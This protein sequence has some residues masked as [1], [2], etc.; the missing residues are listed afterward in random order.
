M[1]SHVI[2]ANPTS[3]TA[4]R[5]GRF[6]FWIAVSMSVLTA[7]TLA[8]AATTLPRSGP[9]CQSGCVAYPY[10]DIAAFFPRDYVWMWL[11]LLMAP[12]FVVLM[13][14][15][16]HYAALEQKLL[17]LIGLI[18]ASMAAVVIA[19]VYFV[20]LTVIQPSL[21]N[22]ETAGIALLTQYNPHGIFIALE[23]LGYLLMS[24][25]F[26]FAGAV[27]SAPGRLERTLRWIFMAGFG[28]SVGGLIVL[29]LIYGNHLEYRFEVLVIM[30]V[31]LVLIVT[32]ALLSVLFRRT[33][34]NRA[35]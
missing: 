8:V 34:H 2:A 35:A 18:F 17:S 10:T 27:F 20:Q 21:L 7:V 1:T 6:S 19:I 3:S 31:W 12:L 29:S 4:Q 26:G 22:G 28:L 30:V 25:A 5:G 15:I 16:H 11:A 9:F 13:A 33:G 32:G 23:S 14:C 24:V